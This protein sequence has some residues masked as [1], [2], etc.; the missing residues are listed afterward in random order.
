MSQRRPR[1]H[2]SYRHTALHFGVCTMRTAA[3]ASTT[4]VVLGKRPKTSWFMTRLL[5]Y[6]LFAKRSSSVY[7]ALCDSLQNAGVICPLCQ[8]CKLSVACF[9]CRHTR[10]SEHEREPIPRAVLCCV[11]IAKRSGRV[12]VCSV[13]PSK[14]IV[15]L[16]KMCRQF[17]LRA[18][19]HKRGPIPRPCWIVVFPVP[20]TGARSTRRVRHD[21]L[22][23]AAILVKLCRQFCQRAG[24]HKRKHIPRLCC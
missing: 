22:P 1:R 4:N 2:L 21:P 24:E 19:A 20:S 7:R 12:Y 5:C 16:L 10:A 17:W 8:A 3:A 6:A 14:N 18:G 13:I 23:K 9:T 15:S 11:P